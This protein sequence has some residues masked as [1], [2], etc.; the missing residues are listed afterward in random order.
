MAPC[1]CPFINVFLVFIADY[2]DFIGGFDAVRFVL[3]CIVIA[4]FV[5]LYRLWKVEG[6]AA[7]R[8][9]CGERKEGAHSW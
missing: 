8:G 4:T 6:G 1:G 2:A 9:G 5:M 7:K 3:N